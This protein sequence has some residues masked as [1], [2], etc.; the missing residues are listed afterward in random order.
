MLRLVAYAPDGVRRFP[1]HRADML[2]G[3]APECDLCLP[4]IGV[5]LRHARLHFEG[6]A[7]R[8]EDLGSRK[9]LLVS[10]RKVREAALEVLDEI[11]IGNVTLLVEDIVPQ[12][13]RP[14]PESEAARAERRAALPRMTSER[15]VEYLTRI[16][17]WVLADTESRTSSEALVSEVLADFGGGVLFLLLGE[18][19]QPGVKLVVGSDP[20]WMGKGDELLDQVR[21]HRAAGDGGTGAAFTGELAGAA[22]WI[23]YHTFTALDRIYTLMTAFPGYAPDSWSPVAALRSLGHL[24][25]F[26][27]VHHVGWYEPILPGNLVQQDLTL[28]PGLVLGESPAMK[29]VTSQLRVAIGLGDHGLLRGEAGVGKEPLA[30]SLHLSGPRRHGPFV[31]ALCSG[32]RPQQLEADLFGAEVAGRGGVVRRE[33]KLLLAHG[34]T[35]FLDD[36][37]ELPLEVQARLVRFLRSG[38]VEPCGSQLA[39][40]A[41]V[42]IIAGSRVPLEDVVSRDA[43]RVDLHYHLSRFVIDVPPL[44][45]RREDLPLLIQ[46]YINRF[47]HE[48]GKRLTGITVKAMS[49][50]LNYDYPGNAAELENIMRHLV[51]LS[52]AGRPVDVSLLPEKVRRGG[53]TAGARVDAGSDLDLERLVGGCE[54]AAI[55]EA[56]RR[57]HGNKSQAARLLGLSRNGLAIKMDRHGL[58]S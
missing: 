27:L 21:A 46:S 57:T 56:L 42:R 54:Q 44:R 35:L 37:E 47:C 50:L 15:M 53:L 3:S 40:P 1:L 29:A 19:E 32:A 31:T 11:R 41:D 33:G 38:E 16:S 52:P 20:L 13:E 48:T 4:Y 12:P 34:G 43:F 14:A 7:L 55:R 30:R 23:C 36:V 6:D 18:M 24:L 26:G 28:A 58:K 22:A 51:Y 10:G 9:G 39:T 25:V 45:E 49:A 2:I 5:A 8:I 17:E